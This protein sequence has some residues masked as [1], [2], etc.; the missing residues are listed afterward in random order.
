[1]S[2]NPDIAV[3]LTDDPEQQA[4]Y[5]K[6]ASKLNDNIPNY[7]PQEVFSR[8]APE[9][10]NLL[11]DYVEYGYPLPEVVRDEIDRVAE[12]LGIHPDALINMYRDALAKVR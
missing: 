1:M 10:L 6:A 4:K 3:Y 8:F 12:A 7:T 5:T 11:E 9:S 2:R